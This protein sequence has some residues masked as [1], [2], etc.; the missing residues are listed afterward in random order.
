MIIEKEKKNEEVKAE[1]CN[2]NIEGKAVDKEGDGKAVGEEVKAES[3]NEKIEGKTVDKEGTGKTVGEEGTGKTNNDKTVGEENDGKTVDKEG[4]TTNGNK[5]IKPESM[6]TSSIF[7]RPA[8]PVHKESEFLKERG[9]PL[10]IE[11]EC[12]DVL[13]KTSSA[14]NTEQDKNIHFKATCQLFMFSENTGAIEQRGD[15][16]IYI[17]MV[18][19]HKLYKLTM[20]R[21]RIYKL[22]CNHFILP[23]GKLHAHKTSANTFIWHTKNDKCDDDVKSEKRTFVVKFGCGEDAERFESKYGY[24]MGENAKVLSDMKK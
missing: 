9:K 24:A 21:D 8:Q 7:D 10:F 23:I 15:G 20:V 17:K 3:C 4:P 22:G 6:S 14:I 16:I 5:N 19:K 18:E 11:K 1:S 2:E 13:N 12:S